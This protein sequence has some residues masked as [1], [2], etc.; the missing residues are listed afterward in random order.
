MGEGM[1]GEW[2]F[3]HLDSNVVQKCLAGQQEP[4]WGK[5]NKGKCSLS[6][7]S[8]CV[9]C[10]KYHVTDQ[11]QGSISPSLTQIGF[12]LGSKANSSPTCL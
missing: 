5:A 4:Y 11:L 3:L 9:L 7:L 1:I 2:A 6:V 8:Q 12:W 10:S